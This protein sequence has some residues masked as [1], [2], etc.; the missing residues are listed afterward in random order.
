MKKRGEDANNRKGQI[1]IFIILAIVVVVLGIV[2]YFFYPK[3][4]SNFGFESNPS[5][6]MESCIKEDL[7]NT[8]EKI[9]SQGGSLEPEH[10]IMYQGN[11]I[12][13][14]CYTEEYYTTCIMQQPMLKQHI[15]KEVQEAIKSKVSECFDLLKE[16]YEKKGYSVNLKKGEISIELLP[17][18]IIALFNST[19]TIKKEESQKYDS[20]KIVL[21]NN[22]YELVSIAN[23]ILN[24]EARYGDSETTTYMDYYHDLKVEK[25]KQSEGSTI[26]ILTDRTSENKF[27]F[28]SRSVAWPPGYGIDKV[29]IENA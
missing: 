8:V 12:E 28:A 16:D 23:S 13:Y 17:Q 18:R 14:L 26:Y 19:L 9:S 15:E 3:I 6:Y 10:Y 7:T 2:L 27:Q 5:L 24:W 21:N 11:K 22:L 20:I 4:I 29:Y 1:T 25:K